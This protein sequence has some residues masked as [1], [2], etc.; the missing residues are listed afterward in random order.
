M[1][2][3]FIEIFLKNKHANKRETNSVYCIVLPNMVEIHSLS[4]HFSMHKVLTLGITTF[5]GTFL[6]SIII[7]GGIIV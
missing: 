1:S 7:S 5:G 2:N 6:R 4:L 3:R